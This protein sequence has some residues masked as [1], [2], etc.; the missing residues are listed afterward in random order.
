MEYRDDLYQ[1]YES[2]PTPLSAQSL[3]PLDDLLGYLREY[4]REK[5]EI[6][7][8]TCFGFGFILGWKLKPW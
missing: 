6:V 8:L 1:A 3:R 7:A 5:P 4:A 2:E